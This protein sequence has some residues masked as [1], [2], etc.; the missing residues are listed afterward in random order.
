MQRRAFLR[1]APAGVAGVSLNA[2]GAGSPRDAGPGRILLAYF[3][4]PGENY[5]N[6]GRRNLE[7]GNILLASPIWNVTAPMI[8]T[9]FAE[10]YD[11]S[12]KTVHPS[13]RTR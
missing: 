10:R 9:T 7:V 13:R 8:M 1:L 12:G 6:G 2:C 5:W 11:F 3:S 4:R